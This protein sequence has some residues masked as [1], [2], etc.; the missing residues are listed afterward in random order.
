MFKKIFKYLGIAF[1][2]LLF[3]SFL[4]E[5]QKV[6]YEKTGGG[7]GKIALIKI[8]GLLLTGTSTKGGLFKEIVT[9]SDT[10]IE[11]LDDACS[12]NYV[13]AILLRVNS[14]GGSV[15]GSQEI[16]QEIENCKKQGK[17]VV[18]SM[19][20][21]AASGAY[22]ISS[23]ADEIIANPGTLTGSIGVIW[24]IEN[25]KNLYDK[26][27]IQVEILKK[28]KFKD[29]GNPLRKMTP[30]ERQ[31]FDG[32]LNNAY[33]QFTKDV[34]RGRNIKLDELKKIADGRVL[35]GE[36]A[37][38]YKLVDKLGNYNL[39]VQEAAKLGGIEGKPFVQEYKE[40]ENFLD[41][42]LG[43]KNY[44]SGVENILKIDLPFIKV[45]QFVN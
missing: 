27:G 4:S 35:T 5:Y 42:L 6:N 23:G 12:D 2:I 39:A 22:Y 9:G 20:D 38:K 8:Q 21:V 29:A 11:L 41:I 1:L 19:G 36:Q 7:K 10:I 18:V 45:K 17:K 44:F 43:A 13:K 3:F 34:A 31:L 25:V 30:E 16:L 28:G 26:I 24:S 33:Q 15:A 32:L 40:K 14:P 37:L